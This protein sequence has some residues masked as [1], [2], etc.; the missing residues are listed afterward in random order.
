MNY[1]GDSAQFNLG[2]NSLQLF[3]YLGSTQVIFAGADTAVQAQTWHHIALNHDDSL[4]T[5]GT[6]TLYID[7]QARATATTA[8]PADNH[9]GFFLGHNTA[10]STRWISANYQDVRFYKGTKK[11]TGNF[12]PASAKPDILP[13]SPSGI[14]TKSKLTKITDGAVSFGTK[15]SENMIVAESA[16]FGFGTGDWT[17][18]GYFYVSTSGSNRVLWDLRPDSDY[19]FLRLNGTATYLSLI[20]I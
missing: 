13:D 8:V 5:N 4:G 1:S 2:I 7:G 11:Y 14:A 12:I 19:Y 16:D 6:T 17:V 15:G 18:E 9:N 10:H 3:A 20:H